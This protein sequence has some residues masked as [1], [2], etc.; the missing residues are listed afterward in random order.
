MTFTSQPPQIWSLISRLVTVFLFDCALVAAKG[1]S[2]GR[3]LHIEHVSPFGDSPEEISRNLIT[4]V[5]KSMGLVRSSR[6]LN[7][8]T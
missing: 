3:S 6:A 4:K 1:T 5:I 8:H 7:A 2:R